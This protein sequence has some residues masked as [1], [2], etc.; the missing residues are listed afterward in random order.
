MITYDAPEYFNKPEE[1]I[2]ENIEIVAD[3]YFRSVLLKE[4]GTVIPQHKHTYDHATLV[5]SGKA[6]LWVNGT[7]VGDYESGKAVH[8][9]SNQ[10]HIF[11]SLEPNTRL[12]CIHDTKSAGLIKELEE[13]CPGQ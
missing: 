10:E 8:I 2:V 4:N 3:I 12:V 11:Q 9:K 6:R 7:W 1:E 13:S 5:A